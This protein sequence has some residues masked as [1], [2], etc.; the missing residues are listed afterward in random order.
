MSEE[1]RTAKLRVEDLKLSSELL[2]SSMRVSLLESLSKAP[3]YREG[4]ETNPLDSHF[5]KQA[6][7]DAARRWVESGMDQLTFTYEYDAAARK[8]VVHVGGPPEVV[9]KLSWAAATCAGVQRL[10][11]ASLPDGAGSS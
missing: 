10:R 1:L 4:V 3:L 8:V 6:F 5:L 11:R 9:S 7:E 2:I